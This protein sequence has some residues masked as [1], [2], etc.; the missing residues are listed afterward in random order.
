LQD[1]VI[2]LAQVTLAG[3]SS[4]VDTPAEELDLSPEELAAAAEATHLSSMA[5]ADIEAAFLEGEQRSTGYIRMA[6]A[7]AEMFRGQGGWHAGSTG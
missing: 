2:D 4:A 3:P 7:A 1:E 6:A 5:V